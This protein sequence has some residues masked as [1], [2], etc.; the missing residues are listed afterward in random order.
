MNRFDIFQ[1]FFGWF[2]KWKTRRDTIKAMQIRTRDE[3]L[4]K[5]F[6]CQRK[7]LDFEKA[8]LTTDFQ[9]FSHYME[10]LNWMLKQ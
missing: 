7:I 10:M 8:K 9:K 6:E 1:F 5:K 2:F 3:I 4:N